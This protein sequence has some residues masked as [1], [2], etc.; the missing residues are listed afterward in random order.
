MIVLTCIIVGHLLVLVLDGGCRKIDFES[1][2]SA[3][4]VLKSP[5]RFLIG[6]VNWKALF[7]NIR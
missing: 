7:S 2:L 1:L 4:V 6:L 5:G 3:V